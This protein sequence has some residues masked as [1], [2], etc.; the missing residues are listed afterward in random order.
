MAQELTRDPDLWLAEPDAGA[1]LRRVLTLR[2]VVALYVSSVLGS[3]ILVLPGLAA[4]LAGPGSLVA[5]VVLAAGSYPFAVTFR[6][7]LGAPAGVRRHLRLHREAFGVPAAN[8]TGWLFLLWYVAGAPAVTLIAASYLGYAFPLGP[9][10]ST[11]AAA[12]VVTAAYLAN[13]RGIR[14]SG[15]VQVAV[16]AAIVGL[17]AAAVAL[18]AGSVEARSFRPFLPHGWLPVGTA[19]ALIFWSF[20][21]YENVSN[22]AGEL[23]DPER[24]LH[25]GALASVVLVGALYLAVALVTVGTRAQEAGAAWPPSR[26]FSPTCWAGTARPARR[27]WPW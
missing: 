24:D 27:S 20:L 2:Q 19:G 9:A 12:G 7:P 15:R 4:Q 21:G 26:P 16:V 23:R 5:W 18:S 1:A 6:H 22:M 13:L 11:L 10:G 25:R 17:L 14:F 3:G 8:V